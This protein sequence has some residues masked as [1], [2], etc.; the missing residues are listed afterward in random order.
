M[1]RADKA[2]IRIDMYV[3]GVWMLR[4]CC[5]RDLYGTSYL[6]VEGG[7]CGALRVT[8]DV[9]VTWYISTL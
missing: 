9:P 2:P 7:Y 3:L 1:F 6:F 5:C 4:R 8:Y